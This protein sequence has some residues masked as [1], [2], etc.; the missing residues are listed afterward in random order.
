MSYSHLHMCFL[1]KLIFST[2][3]NQPTCN[4]LHR[5]HHPLLVSMSPS[6]H[7][8]LQTMMTIDPGHLLLAL[9]LLLLFLLTHLL[10]VQQ[11]LCLLYHASRGL[12][13]C[14]QSLLLPHVHN[15]NAVCL[16]GLAMCMV[17]MIPGWASKGDWVQIV[18]LWHHWEIWNI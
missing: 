7:C 10:L 6:C 4:L 15:M 17:I 2:V 11:H 18:L 16:I 5:S 13:H 1:L 3:W 8:P 12:L 14:L 9:R